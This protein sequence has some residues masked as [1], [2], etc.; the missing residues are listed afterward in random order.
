M[1]G[2]EKNITRGP[3]M[4]FE[5]CHSIKIHH[6]QLTN[7]P[8]WTVHPIYCSNVYIHH[9]H[10]ENPFFEA[11]NTDGI[12]PDSSFNVKID[13]CVINT[14]DDCIAIKSGWVSII[15]EGR[16]LEVIL[17]PIL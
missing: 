13:Q 7:S 10:V 3:L 5:N 6:L 8:F 11:P 17:K 9:L 2:R 16:D 1:E 15:F 14:G 12:N 4:E